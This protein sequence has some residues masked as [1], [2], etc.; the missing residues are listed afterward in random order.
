MYHYG[1]Y[2]DLDDIRECALEHH[3]ITNPYELGFDFMFDECGKYG[4]SPYD[5]L[6]GF[7]DILAQYLHDIIESSLTNRNPIM[8]LNC[9]RA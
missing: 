4:Y 8:C 5:F 9:C 6:H 7:C 3:D 1:F 2:N